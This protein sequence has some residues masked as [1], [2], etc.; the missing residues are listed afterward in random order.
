MKT[1]Y[2]K[3]HFCLLILI[4]P[5]FSIESYSQILLSVEK[6][7]PVSSQEECISSQ[8]HTFLMENDLEYRAKREADEAYLLEYAKHP[9]TEKAI[10]IIK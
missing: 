1:N 2:K 7:F 6:K 4:T 8:R 5:L 10:K 3:L 9:S